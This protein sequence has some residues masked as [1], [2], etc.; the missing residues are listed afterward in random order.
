MENEI[1]SPGPNIEF[2]PSGSLLQ[3]IQGLTHQ[4]INR[5]F[6]CKKCSAGC[7]ANFAMDLKT[8]EIVRLIQLGDRERLLS[9]NS[10]WVCTSCKTCKNRC[11]NDIDSSAIMDTLKAIAIQEGRVKPDNRVNA[12][13]SS[14]LAT[15]KLLGRT[16]ELGMIGLYKHKTKTYTDDMEMGLEMFK[17][18]KMKILPEKIRGTKQIKKIFEIAKEKRV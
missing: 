9:S 10:Y 11:P 2:S 14:F 1:C 16:H 8:N 13:H 18:G 3:E 4:N 12:F 7:P 15:V 17:R 5:C 6:Q